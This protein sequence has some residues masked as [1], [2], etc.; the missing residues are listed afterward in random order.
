MN[1]IKKNPIGSV[2]TASLFGI[3]CLLLSGP[4][5]Q[6]RASDTHLPPTEKMQ[7][8]TI[9]GTIISSEDNVPIP[10]A[11]VVEKGT[12]NGTTTDFDGNY[13]I[14]V[15]SSEAILVITYIG[16]TPQEITVGN[17]STVDVTL[18]ADI[19]QLDEVVVVGYGTAKK[20]TLSGSIEQVK[21]EVFEDRAVTNVGL[22][23]QGQ[24]PGLVVNRNT[25]RP[26]SDGISL[27]I[28]GATSV[29]GGSPLIV[30]D[31]APVFDDDEFFLMN[32]DDIQSISVL[33]DGA[34][35]IY[36]SRAANGV[37]LVTTKRGK[38][39]MKVEF[40]TMVRANFIGINPPVPSMQQYGQLWLDAAEQD[41][42]SGGV[43]NYWLWGEETVRGFANGE[44]RNYQT[45]VP[46]WGIDGLV[47]MAPANRFPDLYGSNTGRQNT[48][49]IA[50]GS[51]Q[52]TY[53]LSIGESQSQ[54]ALKTAFDG[55]NQYS[56]RLNTDFNITDK[57]KV[58]ANIA[59][60]KNATSSPSS[61][62]GRAL[63][64]QDAP[65]FP[66]RNPLGQYY[67]N[68]GIG[69]TNSVAATTDGGRND[70]VENNAKVGVNLEYIIGYGFSTRFNST[71]NHI[72][73]RRVMTFIDVPY[74]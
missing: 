64:N 26:G 50:G 18:E 33:K 62:F 45:L 73:S 31:G 53:R 17:K 65:V 55:I 24:T 44:A 39:K 67:G 6:L 57:L 19:S 3:W 52:A 35:S 58:S 40:N 23:L 59:L 32:P 37:I 38:G 25:S 48:L 29:N 41:I 22:A 72:N 28:R 9:T 49:S 36:G 15:S 8:V 42:G 12:S 30:I 66:V 47:F 69:G 10:G 74:I 5:N 68:F 46:Q 43:P 14:S 51:E 2:C 61:G 13:S 27:Q 54:G 60:N 4:I 21:S 1:Q 16:F 7:Q 11:N 34:G 20:E 56:V 71:F 70:I 63:L